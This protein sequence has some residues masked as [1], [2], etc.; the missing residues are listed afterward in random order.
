MEFLAPI[1]AAAGLAA[2]GVPLILHM[3]RRAP[4]QRLPFSLV[5]LLKPSRPRLT[6][7]STIEHWPLLLL[8]IL[9]V[10]LL[11]LAFSR[12]FQRSDERAAADS[13]AGRSVTLLIDRSAS[14]R[15]DGIRDE[16]VRELRSAVESL[17]DS[18]QLQVIVFSG[19]PETVLS[20]EEWAAAS[21]GERTVAIDR[22]CA[23]YT[24][25][26]QATHT[27]QALLQTAEELVQDGGLQTD[28]HIILITDFQEG[29]DLSTLH[30]ADWPDAVSISLQ[31][32]TAAD[33]GNASLRT[34]VDRRTGR[35]LVRIHN[36]ADASA[37]QFQVRPL[38]STGLPAGPE[39]EME[40]FPGRQTSL[41]LDRFTP[42]EDAT[43][44]ALTGDTHEF[45]NRIPLPLHRP[46][47]SRIAHVGSTD[48]NDADDMRY[49]LQRAMDGML[50]DSTE[51]DTTGPETTI[52]D[53]IT[54]DGLV[55]PIESD[56][57]LAILTDD[58]PPELLPSLTSVLDRGGVLVVALRSAVMAESLNDLL[59]AGVTI[60]EA[61][62]DDYAM[63]GQIDF[64]HP[65]FARFSEARFADF[66]SI[67]F[68]QHRAITLTPPTDEDSDQ[69]APWT[70]IARFDSGLPAIVRLRHESDGYLYLLASGW[71]PDD[72]QWAL[73]SRFAP[74]L[75]GFRQLARPPQ[76]EIQHVQVGDVIDPAVITATADWQLQ[77]PDGTMLSAE[78]TSGSVD[79]HRQIRIEQPGIY[80]LCGT[81]ED[82]QTQ[83]TLLSQ[84][85]PEE[86]LTTALPE[87]QLYSMELTGDASTGAPQESV[88]P[89][90]D[91][92]QAS[93]EQL[94]ASQQYWRW[95]LLAGLACLVTEAL[96]AAI[97]HRRQLPETV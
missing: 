79:R 10:V 16:V 71:H 75:S 6:R 46:Q 19:P 47:V 91:L 76:S 50:N 7:R 39:F 85:A 49:Y 67:R 3:L 8:R 72:S 23:E 61:P 93:A 52:V 63:L 24:P 56:I 97:I 94:E 90:S 53:A 83:F 48:V 9:A 25:D 86:S 82:Q 5:R 65:L 30:S 64:E 66:S 60:T 80:Q 38:T 88:S 14:M 96:L 73:S 51:Q 26:W 81:A 33:S 18:D 69:P 2:A 1:F 57:E 70:V 32:I 92:P 13:S 43:Q 34:M 45:D 55:L 78:D 68:W 36:S 27:G 44:L 35:T 29:S 54:K 21:A 20:F 58:V 89:I 62:L 12:P 11:G 17:S 22:L 41:P 87:G 4:T 59:P 37:T 74:M 40:A 95:L 28:H 77:F 84:L 15:R 31:R 42:S